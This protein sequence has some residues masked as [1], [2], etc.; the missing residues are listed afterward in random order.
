MY[1]NILHDTGS[2][3]FGYL[4]PDNFTLE[5]SISI[6]I[7]GVQIGTYKCDIYLESPH[8]LKHHLTGIVGF[9]ITDSLYPALSMHMDLEIRD[10]ETGFVFYRR[11]DPE[12]HIPKRVFRLETQFA[13]QNILDHSLKSYFQFYAVNMDRYGAET[14]RQC[15]E[16]INQS[17]TYVSGR[18]YMNWCRQFLSDDTITF[19]ALRDPFYEFA[20]RLVTISQY[21]K[22][23]FR[24]LP[25][26]DVLRFQPAIEYFADL[27]IS[28]MDNIA[29]AIKKAPKDV[30]GLFRSPFT[31]QLV[32]K[33]PS[34]DVQLGD[35]ASALEV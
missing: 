32:A 8:K 23:Q 13:P 10:T 4:I 29:S 7:N 5:P 2:E 19:A 11:F 33:S 26:R 34:D 6:H 15:F 9:K 27:N 20:I 30:M 17:S 35:V 21:E 12:R 25:A 1:F 24:F 3:I 18:V 31:Q 16:V 28:D 14:I 22:R